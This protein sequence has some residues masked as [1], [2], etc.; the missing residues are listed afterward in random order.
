MSLPRAAAR[1]TGLALLAVGTLALAQPTT[2][3]AETLPKTYAGA[4]FTTSY[5]LTP[6]RS[7]SQHKIWF[8]D[9]SWWALMLEPKGLTERVFQLLPNHTWRPTPAVLTTDT[10]EVGDAVQ[11]GESVHVVHRTS[12][13]ALYYVRLTFDQA[14]G[15]YRAGAPRL[16]TTRKSV[17]PV[18]I[19][20]DATGALWVSYA[21][22]QSVV[23]TQSLDGGQTWGRM[24]LLA[25]TGTGQTQEAVALVPYDDRIGILW[26]DQEKG[27]FDFASHRNGDD[28][29]I[30]SR[31]QATVPGK[32]LADN[33]ISLVRLRVPGQSSDTLVAAVKTSL[34]DAGEA[35]TSPRVRILVRAPGGH[36][37]TATAGTLAD[38]LDDPVLQVDQATRTVRLFA[39]RNGPIVTKVAPWSSLQFAPGAGTVFM[40]TTTDTLADPIVTADPVDARSGLVV[41][42]TD[43]ET[44][45]YRHAEQSLGLPVPTSSDKTPPTA[46][47]SVDARAVSPDTAVVSW[48]PATDGNQWVPAGDGVPVSKYLLLRN[49]TQIAALTSTSYQ[50]RPRAG[51]DTKEAASVQ[52]SVIA[53]DAAGNR[54]AAAH[55]VVTL[56][57]A[58]D[59]HSLTLAGLG[60]LVLAALAGGYGLWRTWIG[61]QIAGKDTL[62]GGDD[63]DRAGQ[64]DSRSDRPHA[65]AGAS[66]DR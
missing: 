37:T 40:N 66:P 2:A 11:D 51:G 13:G 8:H 64:G 36:W 12:N 65:A 49:G 14:A 39:D 15:E 53:V 28:P 31:E 44:K 22:A 4:A 6:T 29:T 24:N 32:G 5:H 58:T 10:G 54:S 1:R 61:R 47:A 27:S 35:A 33:H 43:T 30:W 3:S 42:A 17:A 55:A 62:A 56:P 57:A 59:T 50:D 48:A 46:P 9:G 63:A 38:G 16:V 25:T 26:S 7:E 52:Y 20:K 45:T 18:V 21:T 41:L 23:V 60:L 19:T 34:G